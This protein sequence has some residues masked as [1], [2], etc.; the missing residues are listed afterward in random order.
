MT[1]FHEVRKRDGAARIGQLQLSEVTHT[2]LMLTVEHAE[3]L[4][5][6]TAADSNFND[7]AS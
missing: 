2:P 7:L 1:K 4:K 3:E 5:E 6:L